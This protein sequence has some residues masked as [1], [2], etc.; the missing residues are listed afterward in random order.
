MFPCKDR[1][2]TY[3]IMI[4]ERMTALLILHP[5]SKIGEKKYSSNASLNYDLL[6]I[7]VFRFMSS[8]I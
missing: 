2:T 8:T 3:F 4:S 1:I 6:Q 7:L 5:K